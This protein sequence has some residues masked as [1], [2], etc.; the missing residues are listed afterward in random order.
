VKEAKVL[1][2][3]SLRITGNHTHE[4]H[5][6]IESNGAIDEKKDE[7]PHKDVDDDNGNE[8]CFELSPTFSRRKTTSVRF[9]GHK[10]SDVVGRRPIVTPDVTTNSRAESVSISTFFGLS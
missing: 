8:D 2:D 10:S 6:V 7:K 5:L 9:I 4:V 3:I 1:Q